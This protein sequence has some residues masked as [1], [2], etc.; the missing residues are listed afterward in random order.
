[1]K[2]SVALGGR[3]GRR[4]G[5]TVHR[6]Y[7]KVLS[8]ARGRFAYLVGV[9][10]VHRYEGVHLW[11]FVVAAEAQLVEVRLTRLSLVDEDKPF[12]VLRTSAATNT[13]DVKEIAIVAPF[14]VSSDRQT[15]LPTAI[16]SPVNLSHPLD[17]YQI[18]IVAVRILCSGANTGTSSGANNL[19]NFVTKYSLGSN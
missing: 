2:A 6:R 17:K 11:E 13:R 18:K 8:E 16:D 1:M 9:G 19:H 4:C 10:S 12:P 14:F 5:Q 3:L 7:H 15:K